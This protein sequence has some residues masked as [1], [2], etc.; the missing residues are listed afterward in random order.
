MEEEKVKV[1]VNFRYV[2]EY[3]EVVAVFP[4]EKDNL[5]MMVCYARIGQHSNCTQEWIDECTIQ[6]PKQLY[7]DLKKELE[8]I[9]YELTTIECENCTPRDFTNDELRMLY[10]GVMG[11]AGYEDG[12][13]LDADCFIWQKGTE[14]SEIL[15]W[16][17]SLCANGIDDIL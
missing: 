11:R 1:I 3:D 10:Y 14:R 9:G 13:Y 6:C 17:D 12:R 16:F 2:P 5:K 15:C 7:Q 4:F 8:D